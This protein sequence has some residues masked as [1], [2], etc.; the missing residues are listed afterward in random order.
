MENN[1]KK[2]NKSSPVKRTLSGGSTPKKSMSK[3][4][5]VAKRNDLARRCGMVDSEDENL[6]EDDRTSATDLL[7]KKI[8]AAKKKKKGTKVNSSNTNKKKSFK[9]SCST[10]KAG[11]LVK[12]KRKKVIDSSDDEDN[13]EIEILT[14]EEHERD[15]AMK[16]NLKQMLIIPTCQGCKQYKSKC[17]DKVLGPFLSDTFIRHMHELK[18]ENNGGYG[19]KD[20]RDKNLVNGFVKDH[21]LEGYNLL[22]KYIEHSNVRTFGFENAIALPSCIMDGSYLDTLNQMEEFCENETIAELE[23]EGSDQLP[24]DYNPV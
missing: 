12:S 15:Q 11:G 3:E 1:N 20:C 8:A 23:N 21:F 19:W 22:K 2:K 6:F 17:Y 14:P 7:I 5:I 18:K 16:H 4:K 13:D 9:K 10:K 24:V